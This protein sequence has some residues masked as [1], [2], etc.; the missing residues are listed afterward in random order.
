MVEGRDGAPSPSLMTA[1]SS[2]PVALRVALSAWNDLLVCF[3]PHCPR[4]SCLTL[5]PV[6]E[7]LGRPRN[8][9]RCCPWSSQRGSVAR[10]APGCA[11][12]R[13]LS[14]AGCAPGR[15]CPWQSSSPHMAA[16]T[17]R[18]RRP[19]LPADRDSRV[20]HQLPAC[21]SRV[22]QGEPDCAACHGRH[23]ARCG[24]PDRHQP[25]VAAACR[26]PAPAPPRH[27][28]AGGRSDHPGAW[29][30]TGEMLVGR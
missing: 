19:A 1:Q 20:P 2:S 24:A 4:P 30:A 5:A 7:E 27:A 11:A 14:Q 26:R 9:G 29:T 21:T 15:A 8:A 10:F 23:G 6:T 25:S 13:G 28:H 16:P 18:R 17:Q 3:S 22:V 12:T